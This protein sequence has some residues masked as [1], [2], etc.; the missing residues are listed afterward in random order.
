VWVVIGGSAGAAVLADGPCA[1]TT[2]GLSTVNAVLEIPVDAT[3]AAL[4]AIPASACGQQLQAIDLWT[5]G[6]SA[7]VAL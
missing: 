5:C 6:T 2:T 7:V 4:G 1:G 3:G